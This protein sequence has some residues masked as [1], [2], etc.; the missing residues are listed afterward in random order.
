[1]NASPWSKYFCASGLDVATVRVCTPRPVYWITWDLG[2]PSGLGGS[3]NAERGP[4]ATIAESPTSIRMFLDRM[5]RPPFIFVS[6][7]I[8]LARQWPTAPMDRPTLTF[9]QPAR[10]LRV[11]P[12]S[13]W[14]RPRAPRDLF[15]ET[16]P[17]AI[18]A[19]RGILILRL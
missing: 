1:M 5:M 3:P 4:K 10:T 15:L 14:D 6:S 2:A 8:S 9:S 17:S 12:P 19:F 7:V 11:H 13:V 18:A 16:P